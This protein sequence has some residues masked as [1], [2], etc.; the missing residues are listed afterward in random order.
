MQVLPVTTQLRDA[1]DDAQDDGVICHIEIAAITRLIARADDGV[2]LGL[3]AMKGGADARRVREGREEFARLHGPI[4]FQAYKKRQA[5]ED[6]P[7][8]A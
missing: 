1:W 8:A 3:S 5:A 7:D 6:G 2:R 4:N